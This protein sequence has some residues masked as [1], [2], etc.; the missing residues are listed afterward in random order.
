MEKCIEMYAIYA[1]RSLSL[2]LSFKPKKAL[3]LGSQ[4]K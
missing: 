1:K 4:I 3:R 2:A